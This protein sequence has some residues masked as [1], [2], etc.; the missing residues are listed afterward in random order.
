MGGFAPKSAPPGIVGTLGLL[1]FLWLAFGGPVPL[2]PKGYRFTYV[3][4]E[5]CN[6]GLGEKL[7]DPLQMYLSDVLTISINL[8]GL[9]A[10]K[11]V[12]VKKG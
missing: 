3:T 2:K 1:L 5:E 11:D 8:A 10:L 4:A 7:D 12:G 6:S 9:A